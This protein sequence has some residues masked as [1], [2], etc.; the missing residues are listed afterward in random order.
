MVQAAVLPPLVRGEWFPMSWEEFLAWSPDEGQSEWVDGEGIAYVSNSTR[1]A[2]MVKFFGQLLD[3]YVRVL[4]LGEVFWETVL[5]RLPLRPSG[6]M[7]DVF[8]VGRAE[9]GRVY[10][11]WTDAV[12]LLAAEFLSDDSVFR[13]LVEKRDE[14]ERAGISEYPVI[15]ARPDHEE[16]VYLRL[17]PNRRYQKVEPDEQ[18]RYHSEVLPGFWLDPNWFW[19]DPLPNPMTILR[20]IS[21]EA[22]RRL[23]EEVEAES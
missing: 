18:G 19:Q 2:L 7:P 3:M 14:F 22:W 8:V 23:V 21:P 20:R 13:D 9:L 16:F 15:D 10:E 17:D 12:P 1:H 4:D 6:R 11:Q 5:L